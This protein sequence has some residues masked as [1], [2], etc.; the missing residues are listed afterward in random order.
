MKGRMGWRTLKWLGVIFGVA[1]AMWVLLFG[2]VFLLFWFAFDDADTPYEPRPDGY[3]QRA[4][5]EEILLDVRDA[6]VLYEMDSH[7]GF[8]GDGTAT[9]SLKL[10]GSLLDDIEGN[11]LWH[12]LPLPEQL[13][14][15]LGR[16]TDEAGNLLVE[17]I[18]EGYYFF[19]DRHSEATDIF[20]SSAVRMRN[21]RNYSLAVYDADENI[22]YYLAE[23]T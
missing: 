21:S 15:S 5:S 4:I 12:E 16:F 23:D 7:G 9:V 18:D 2:G 13:D 20:D 11:S 17:Q 3:W 19:I 14:G 8:L 10:S 1:A 6:E 22:L